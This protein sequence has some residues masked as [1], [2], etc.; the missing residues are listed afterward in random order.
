LLLP[1]GIKRKRNVFEENKSQPLKKGGK[2]ITE[3]KKKQCDH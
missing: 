1:E 2:K 3:E